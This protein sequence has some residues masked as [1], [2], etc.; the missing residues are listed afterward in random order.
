M[1]LQYLDR[2]YGNRA[3]TTTIKQI[4][5]MRSHTLHL[6]LH[7]HL[8][9]QARP[10]TSTHTHASTHINTHYKQQENTAVTLW[11]YTEK[12]PIFNLGWGIAMT[13]EI[14]M[15]FLNP[16]RCMPGKYPDYAMTASFQMLTNSSL[17]NHP[18]IS[19]I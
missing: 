5:C 19:T 18:T 17:T 1:E 6:Y 16:S 4:V 10:C 9:T 3:H 11:I 7:L 15:V 12:V 2:S 14:F 13:S 8:H